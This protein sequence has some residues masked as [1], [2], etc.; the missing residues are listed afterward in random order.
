MEVVV[1]LVLLAVVVVL[2]AAAAAATVVLGSGEGHA[3]AH[4]RSTES[5]AGCRLREVEIRGYIASSLCHIEA[6][7]EGSLHISRLKRPVCP[8]LFL[9]LSV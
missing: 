5:P 6:G 1:V 3:I 4:S 7:N 8:F 9:W 2:V